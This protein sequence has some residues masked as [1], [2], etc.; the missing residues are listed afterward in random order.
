[1][2]ILLVTGCAGPK[3]H[4]RGE[5]RKPPAYKDL[6][7]AP[8]L[9]SS[10]FFKIHRLPAGYDPT[11]IVTRAEA[12][13]DTIRKF[14]GA[15][16][17]PEPGR[18]LIFSPAEPEGKFLL[19]ANR[20]RHDCFG[21][22]IRAENILVVVG[23]VDDP[24]F[25]TVLR[26]EAGHYALASMLP[27]KTVVP[28]WLDEGLATLFETGIDNQGQPLPN[29]ERLKM[30]R[31]LVKTR[32]SLG[33]DAL[34]KPSI[35]SYVNGSAYAKAYGMLAFIYQNQRPLPQALSGLA[36]GDLTSP[37]WFEKNILL[38]GETRAVFETA[39]KVWLKR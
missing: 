21:R 15:A 33:L 29:H 7:A 5:Y 18:I 37:E 28:F 4:P 38:P 26:H 34:I 11:A 14:L 6:A 19:K 8:A 36:T 13:A 10:G 35:P 16:N 23:A 24:R 17:R 12:V 20:A 22:M 32:F 1:V 39:L 30:L 27:S 25:F 3:L 31:Y 9:Y 2:T